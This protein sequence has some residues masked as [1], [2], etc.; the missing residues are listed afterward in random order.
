MTVEALLMAWLPRQRWFGGKGRDVDGVAIVSG[1]TL[2]EGDPQVRL[3][4][5]E[6]SFTDGDSDLYQLLLGATSGPVWVKVN[7]T[8]LPVSFID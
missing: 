7:V 8:L 3:V 2:L 5:L 1:A 4:L 6:V